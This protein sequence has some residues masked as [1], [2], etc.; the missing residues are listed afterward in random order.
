MLEEEW[1]T[2]PI[3]AKTGWNLDEFQSELFD[4]MDVIRVYSKAPGKE[5][6]KDHPFLLP[7]GSDVEYFASK[8]H[9][10]FVEKLKSARVWGS[11][12]FDGQLVGRDYVL[13]DGD[14]VELRI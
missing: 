10:D 5:P 14:V 8:V 2:I 12:G 9:Q 3:S 1:H 13:Q 4:M 7:T 11:S 6:D